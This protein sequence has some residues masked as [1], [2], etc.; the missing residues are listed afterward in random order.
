MASPSSIADGSLDA[1][2]NPSGSDARGCSTFR[3]RRSSRSTSIRVGRILVAGLNM[4]T[5]LLADGSPDTSFV[6]TCIAP[7]S[8]RPRRRSRRSLRL[9]ACTSDH[10]VYDLNVL[11]DDSVL[12][13]SSTEI[14]ASQFVMFLIKLTPSGD[15]DL[16]FN[17]SGTIPGLLDNRRLRPRRRVPTAGWILPG[18]GSV[19]TAT[20]ASRDSRWNARHDV[21]RWNRGR[22]S[23]AV[24]QRRGDLVCLCGRAGSHRAAGVGSVP[25]WAAVTPSSKTRRIQRCHVRDRRPG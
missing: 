13:E 3:T 24:P 18:R 5:R 19:S 11:S 15:R 2:F 20:S 22:L 23:A 1:S 9:A 21:R 12:I 7:C 6:A 4:V 17:P 8:S 14:N 25:C 10:R 16:A